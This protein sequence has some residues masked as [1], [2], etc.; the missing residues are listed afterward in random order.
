MYA[1]HSIDW[2]ENILIKKLKM[3]TRQAKVLII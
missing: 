2:I 1:N 3:M